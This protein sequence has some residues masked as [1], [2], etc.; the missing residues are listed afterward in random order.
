[1]TVRVG[2]L[3]RGFSDRLAALDEVAIRSVKDR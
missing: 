3:N 1:M 2:L